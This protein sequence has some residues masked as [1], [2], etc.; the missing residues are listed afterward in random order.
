MT[1]YLRP[2]RPPPSSP[3]ESCARRSHDTNA[4]GLLG[5]DGGHALDARGHVG[6]HAHRVV[7]EDLVVRI[8]AEQ[9][10]EHEA[11]LATCER[12]PE[13]EVLGESERQVGGVG[14]SGDVQTVR[15]L[16]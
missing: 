8:T 2:I 4:R 13:T 10:A 9:L 12:G 6:S 5:K 3:G 14:S 15:F 16:P 11:R 1:W 7:I